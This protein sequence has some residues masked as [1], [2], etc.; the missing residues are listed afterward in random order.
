M[1][2]VDDIEDITET[3]YEPGVGQYSNPY[4]VKE[5]GCTITNF[6]DPDGRRF[7]IVSR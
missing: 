7:Q 1:F 4:C 2:P 5:T 3:Q 6:H